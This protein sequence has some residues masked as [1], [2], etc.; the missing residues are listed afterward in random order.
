MPITVSV[1][2][3]SVRVKPPLFM[4]TAPGV[5]QSRE[6]P[7]RS[8]DMAAPLVLPLVG[9]ELGPEMVQRQGRKVGYLAADRRGRYLVSRAGRW[10]CVETERIPGAE[11][12]RRRHAERGEG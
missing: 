6:S 2:I 8:V 1:I 5:G 3:S 12:A 11:L 9:W 4:G 10:T 7:V